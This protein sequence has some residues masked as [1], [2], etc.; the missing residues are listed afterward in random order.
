MVLTFW[1]TGEGSRAWAQKPEQP[2][3]SHA[4][5]LMVRKTGEKDFDEKKTQK[6]GMEVFKDTNNGYG[7]YITEKGS[8]GA[9]PGFEKIDGA[10]KDSKGAKFVSGLDLP[11]RAPGV[12]EF[13]PEKDKNW[14]ME[15][16]YD[17]NAGN[18][19]YV[20]EEG[21]VAVTPGS[22]PG[23]GG[24]KAPKWI[25]GIDLRCRKGGTNAKDKD[26]WKDAPAFGIEVYRD[27]N[28]GNLVYI[29]H[30]GG[31]AVIKEGETKDAGK[32][33]EWLHGLDLGCRKFNEPDFGK[34]TRRWGLE[35]FHDERTG[36][37]IYISEI[38]TL[39]VAKPAGKVTAPT[40][41]VKDPVLR[42]GLSLAARKH[43]EAEFTDATR[44]FGAECFRDDNTG[45][46]VYIVENGG[47][48]VAPAK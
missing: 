45:L 15:V 17:P 25:H 23:A 12:K 14:A 44:R 38:G 16:F 27:L 18:W 26:S 19:I 20:T 9:A 40:P 1:M 33:P 34:D 47:I 35:V 3:W 30:V 8:L 21:R 22:P 36:N 7:L 31:I 5:D 39:A 2:K 37:Y 42:H 48:C 43:G 28:T 32:D 4:F 10:I 11:V 6:F 41:N 29:S 46:Y 24:L 13:N